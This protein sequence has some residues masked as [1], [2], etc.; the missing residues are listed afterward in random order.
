MELKERVILALAQSVP[1]W[2]VPSKL[3][4]E[5]LQ[6]ERVSMNE[7][8]PVFKALRELQDEGKVKTKGDRWP[9][10]MKFQLAP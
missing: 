7:V 1:K 5:I 3:A 4:E 10:H 8:R 9:D 2:R 6:P